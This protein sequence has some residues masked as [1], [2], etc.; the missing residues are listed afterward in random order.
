MNKLFL[1]AA[2]LVS[3][4]VL[5]TPSS[6]VMAKGGE[7]NPAI[8]LLDE[9]GNT[10]KID[11]SGSNNNVDANITNDSS[12]P[13]PVTI[14]GN[15]V[16]IPFSV[17]GL[18]PIKD[19]KFACTVEFNDLVIPREANT[20]EIR[21][22]NASFHSEA[23]VF[24]GE[25]MSFQL[26]HRFQGKLKTYRMPILLTEPFDPVNSVHQGDYH[27]SVLLFHD[28][29]GDPSDPSDDDPNDNLFANCRRSEDIDQS[30][31][32][33]INLSGYMIWVD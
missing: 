7:D 13:I 33:V 26:F 31:A 21:Y 17:I 30:I 28:G 15:S 6:E 8:V 24:V 29:V 32:C 18:C 1:G 14:Q 25:L 5:A 19:S 16:K 4:F 9:N 11:Q 2:A 27:E 3:L 12:N 23:N 22:I 10:V 20:L